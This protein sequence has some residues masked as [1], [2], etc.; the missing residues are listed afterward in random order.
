MSVGLLTFVAMLTSQSERKRSQDA[1]PYAG[2]Q[3][4]K[5]YAYVISGLELDPYSIYPVLKFQILMQLLPTVGTSPT[6]VN[7]IRTSHH[8]LHP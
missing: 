8:H 2:I 1:S 3:S 6:L 7:H 4:P 5:H